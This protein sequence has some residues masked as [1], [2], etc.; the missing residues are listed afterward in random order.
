M[1]FLARLP[2]PSLASSALFDDL[3]AEIDDIMSVPPVADSC[4]SP[5]STV[6]EDD[7]EDYDPYQAVSKLLDNSQILLR[8]ILV[9]RISL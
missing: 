3:R 4:P 1:S 7:S 9:F 8:V 6:E 2:F 5:L